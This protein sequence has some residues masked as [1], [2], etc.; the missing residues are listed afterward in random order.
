MS[1]EEVLK[2]QFALLREKLGGGTLQR[3]IPR[4]TSTSS[5]GRRLLQDSQDWVS[6]PG[7]KSNF[8]GREVIV[9]VAPQ[10]GGHSLTVNLSAQL[11]FNVTLVPEGTEFKTF[12]P[13]NI[14]TVDILCGVEDF[15][16]DFII[17]AQDRPEVRNFLCLEE[18]RRLIR[19]SL[20]FQRL[21]LGMRYVRATRI[22]EGGKIDAC[23]LYELIIRMARLAE[24]GESQ[25]KN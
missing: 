17:D 23:A 11:P 25:I 5:P 14:P 4:K 15:D 24:I 10:I 9:D 6:L 22:I 1:I 21:T 8:G 19:E 20:P 3:C 13:A 12:H 2:E 16:R 7:F 18:V